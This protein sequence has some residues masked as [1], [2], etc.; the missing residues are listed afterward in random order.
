[1]TTGSLD[2]PILPPALLGPPLEAEQRDEVRDRYLDWASLLKRVFGEEILV[3]S[4]CGHSPMRVI[5]AI[6]DAPLVEKILVHLG[7]P[8]ERP[9]IA[10]ARSPPR[11]EFDDEFGDPD[12]GDPDF[13]VNVN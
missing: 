7:L 8:S 2:E 6:D 3:C 5:A 12:F 10:P 13:D 4:R 1:M 9:V 11:L